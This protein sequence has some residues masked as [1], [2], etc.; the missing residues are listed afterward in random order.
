MRIEMDSL[1]M[2]FSRYAVFENL[3]ETVESGVNLILGSNG[4]GKTTLLRIIAGLQK[5][6]SG[7]CRIII[8]GE[9]MDNI[10]Y[11]TIFLCSPDMELYSELTVQENMK[12]LAG[13]M[14]CNLTS[15]ADWRLEKLRKKLYG[16]LSSGYKQRV[17]LMMAFLKTFPILLLDEPEQH[18][19][20]QGISFVTECIEERSDNGLLTVVATNNPWRNWR[21][22][23]NL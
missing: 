5:Q 4:S 16:H 20:K 19:D 8:D 23:V 21:V 22:A 15:F 7:E 12:L 10:G 9:S 14:R 13:L 3:T 2:K 17:R 6:T 1:T 18:L 11:E